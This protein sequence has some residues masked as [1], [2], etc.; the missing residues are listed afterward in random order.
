MQEERNR[1]E[2]QRRSMERERRQWL[3]Y[4][5]PAKTWMAT[6]SSSTDRASTR[7][8]STSVMRLD[9]TCS[10]RNRAREWEKGNSCFQSSFLVS[11]GPIVSIATPYDR[12]V[13][14]MYNY[15]TWVSIFIRTLTTVAFLVSKMVRKKKFEKHLEFI[16]CICY[17]I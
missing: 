12:E 6:C 7:A 11:L 5:P 16:L 10:G 15:C 9:N 14:P 4:K 2:R 13:I 1:E 3:H 8:H 17:F